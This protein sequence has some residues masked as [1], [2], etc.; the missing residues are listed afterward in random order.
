MEGCFVEFQPPTD[1]HAMRTIEC[2]NYVA[3]LKREDAFDE[4]SM[5]RDPPLTG[6]GIPVARPV[7]RFASIDRLLRVPPAQ[8][9]VAL[10][11]QAPVQRHQSIGNLIASKLWKLEALHHRTSLGTH[12][13]PGSP[14]M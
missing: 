4:E 7:H 10:N 3:A 8:A 11:I 2:V 14:A 5:A 12:R 9:R 6:C 1:P 13:S